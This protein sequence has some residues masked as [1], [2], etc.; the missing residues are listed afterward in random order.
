V[1]VHSA[2]TYADREFFSRFL[3]QHTKIS[4]MFKYVQKF[5]GKK[6]LSAQVLGGKVVVGA[7]FLK[8]TTVSKQLF[9][10][11]LSAQLVG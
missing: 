3:H 11:S 6:H 1:A 7:P 8:K 10:K 4:T 5:L 9:R 2:K